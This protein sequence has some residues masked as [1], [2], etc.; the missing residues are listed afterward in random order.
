MRSVRLV[1]LLAVL[2][3][4]LHAQVAKPAGL[5]AGGVA[6]SPRDSAPPAASAVPTPPTLVMPA[7]AKPALT[8]PSATTGPT[9][10]DRAGLA[11]ATRAMKQAPRGTPASS[12]R[13]KPPRLD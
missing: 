1:M 3:A 10:R 11:K 9:A 2:S 13:N 12:G 4:P 6:K 8:P 5:R 7:P